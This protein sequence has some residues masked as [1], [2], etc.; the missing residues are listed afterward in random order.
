MNYSIITNNNHNI[1][2]NKMKQ[3]SEVLVYLENEIL[4]LLDK[5]TED[6]DNIN[7]SINEFVQLFK[8]IT[9]NC[10]M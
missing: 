1:I 3:F 7:K 5:E 9:I 4:N 10:G 8:T 2:L 6:L